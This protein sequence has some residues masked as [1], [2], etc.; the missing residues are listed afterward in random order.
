[1]ENKFAKIAEQLSK[2]KTVQGIMKYV[3]EEELKEQHKKQENNKASGIDKIT[4]VEYAEKL[5]ENIKE[6]IKRMKDMAYTPQAVRR[7]YIPKTGSDQ[8]RPLGIPSYEDRLVQGA[9]ADILNAI[10]EPIFLDISYGFR[11]ER[12]A[13]Q[14]IKKLD[15]IIMRK[16]VNYIVDADIK[17]FLWKCKSGVVNKIFRTY[18]RRPKIRKIYS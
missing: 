7:T 18:N 8:L 6:L 9:M 12:D 17:R 15:E 10:Y 3:N 2:Y 13:H 4:K 11:P 16:K 1:M 5:E 14:A